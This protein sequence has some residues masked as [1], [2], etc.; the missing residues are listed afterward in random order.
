MINYYRFQKCCT[1]QQVHRMLEYYCHALVWNHSRL[2]IHTIRS[3][4]TNSRKIERK[5]KCVQQSNKLPLKL[6]VTFELL[7]VVCMVQTRSYY[8]LMQYPLLSNTHAHKLIRIMQIASI[9][10][11]HEKICFIQESLSVAM[12]ITEQRRWRLQR[13]KDYYEKCEFEECA[14]GLKALKTS[15]DEISECKLSMDFY[16]IPIY[17]EKCEH[18]SSYTAVQFAS[19]HR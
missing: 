14:G 11:M 10:C 13:T 5:S 19:H 9:V 15:Q 3:F 17:L 4:H 7:D 8:K 12:Q 16:T 6:I 1:V 18:G 2:F